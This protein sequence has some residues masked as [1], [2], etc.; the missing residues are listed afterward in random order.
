M[1]IIIYVNLGRSAV[2]RF[3]SRRPTPADNIGS[4][5]ITDLTDAGRISA[6]SQYATCM[7]QRHLH[8]FA[9]EAY[10]FCSLTSE[11][12]KRRRQVRGITV[13]YLTNAFPFGHRRHL[14]LKRSAVEAAHRITSPAC[15]RESHSSCSRR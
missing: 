3:Y 11:C 7:K 2:C 10:V 6:W 14:V 4:G 15:V 13:L 8:S 12:D 9:G 5:G 1:P